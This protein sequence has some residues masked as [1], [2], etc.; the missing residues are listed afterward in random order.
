MLISFGAILGKCSIVQLF[1]LASIEMVFYGLNR[2]I[3][4]QIFRTTDAGGS[5]TIH[6]FGAF[7]GVAA[8]LF[9]SRKQAC[10]DKNKLDDGTYSSDIISMTGTL[11][12]FVFWPSFNGALHVGSD[13]MRCVVNTYLSIST[14]V[15]ASIIVSK[16]THGGQL[17]MEI[18]LNA[19]LSGGVAMGCNALIITRPFGAMLCGAICGIV[20]SLGFAYVKDA[21]KNSRLAIHDTCGVL[22]L[23]GIPGIIGGITSAIV[24]KFGEERFVDN[25]LTTYNAFQGTDKIPRSGSHQAGYQLA[26][27]ALSIGLGCAGGA[28]AGV[29]CWIPIFDVP[30]ED[31][32]FQ[33]TAHWYGCVNEHE[34]IDFMA[35]SIKSMQHD[36]K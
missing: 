11:F 6:V 16:L 14:S 13:A 3:I 19:S 12:L 2:E 9:F 22:Y 31:Q 21:L 33:D 10:K 32:L 20:S 36:H 18:I 7:F 8:S 15:I 25:F 28:L 17:E 4:K 29:F 34:E 5:M 23:H 26:A 35:R 30:T 24:A 27:I 1:V